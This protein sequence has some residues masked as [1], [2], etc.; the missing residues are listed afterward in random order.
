MAT[1][2]ANHLPLEKIPLVDLRLL[3]QTD[4]NSLSLHS[5]SSSSPDLFDDIIVPKIDR[6]NF[7]ESAGSRKQ[8]Y[9]R[10][11]LAPNN[12]ETSTPSIGRRR[13]CAA[14]APVQEHHHSSN[15]PNPNEDDSERKENK[16]IVSI[17]KD[18]FGKS[19][20]IV[21]IRHANA[22]PQLAVMRKRSR[23][24]KAVSATVAAPS[25]EGF[26]DEELLNFGANVVMEIVNRNGCVVDIAALGEVEDPF[27]SELRRRTEGLESEAELLGFMREL[28]GQWGSRRMKRK[29][30]DASDFGDTPYGQQFLS[31]K[32]VSS[33]LHSFFGPQ[34][35]TH[36]IFRQSDKD[37]LA[38][39][40]LQSTAGLKPK[41]EDT[42]DDV[43]YG[44]T[45]PTASISAEHEMQ[46]AVMGADNLADVEIRDL[47]ECSKCN[48]SFDEKDA[49]L[50]HLL[51]SCH[52]KNAKRSRLGTS[53]CDGVIIKDGKF[54]CQFCH[55]I[56]DERHRYNGHVGVHVR[57]YVRSLEASPGSVTAKMDDEPS[58]SEVHS[59]V[60]GASIDLDKSYILVTS[61]ATPNT[62]TNSG[63]PLDKLEVDSVLETY[64]AKSDHEV[65]VDFPYI[66]QGIGAF[67]AQTP[68][69]K[70]SHELNV[71]SPHSRP[72]IGGF[73]PEN[74]TKPNDGLSMD[75]SSNLAVG[76]VPGISIIKSSCE[77]NFISHNKQDTVADKSEEYS[78]SKSRDKCSEMIG[79]DVG[80]IDGASNSIDRELD[81]CW[82][83]TTA[84]NVD[85]SAFES[86]G[87][88][89]ILTNL[90]TEME[91]SGP[92]QET[93]SIS[94][95]N[96]LSGREEN[97]CVENIAN[98]VLPVSAK[99]SR[100]E[101]SE[102]RESKSC[103]Q[104]SQDA[105][106]KDVA[107]DTIEIT[108][109]E[110]SKVDKHC[111]DIEKNNGYEMTGYTTRK[112]DDCYNRV[113]TK[114]DASYEITGDKAGQT[115]EAF[116]TVD[117]EQDGHYEM[118]GNNMVKIDQACSSVDI[119]RN[120]NYG[121][122]LDK[123]RRF[124]EAAVNVDGEQDIGFEMTGDMVEKINEAHHNVDNEQDISY[125]MRNDSVK[126]I[127]KVPNNVNEGQGSGYEMTGGMVERID[128]S[129]ST[130]EGALNSCLDSAT[131]LFNNVGNSAFKTYDR[132]YFYTTP[133]GEIEKSSGAYNFLFGPSGN[134]QNIGTQAVGNGNYPVSVNEHEP[135]GGFGRFQ[136]GY[137]NNFRTETNETTHRASIHQ[138]P[139][140]DA[141]SLVPP[142]CNIPTLNLFS[143]KV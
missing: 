107:T 83:S 76:S 29:I 35:E 64:K 127:D 101:D 138:L 32:E 3:S 73:V 114:Q 121:M 143:E 27:G 50:E 43:C 61:A 70:A 11:R 69:E 39:Y 14:H 41:S 81:S 93:G 49:Y 91:K 90:S 16:Q 44:A 137:A 134:E 48:T 36:P 92:P 40:K 84:N 126:K 42:K 45:S 34:D 21:A 100:L 141:S 79:I 125:K 82:E 55:K 128:K 75:F 7:N 106:V 47:L 89:V 103:F 56:F 135:G 9:S 13:G 5:L 25:G 133:T 53:V 58:L 28:E 1:A 74:S 46:D 8:T 17:L 2:T 15:N 99:M 117:G 52:Q 124:G 63:S 112:I 139:A 108:D 12:T 54:E 57:S 113:N 30:V 96:L 95:P 10:L 23:K 136:A 38:A 59:R 120:S 116:D 71:G 31:C 98:E 24:R 105:S 129:Y 37:N 102:N 142:S 22:E 111:S 18:L 119:G 51:T 122:T 68:I 85:T 20:Q 110:I 80:K 4:L 118:V 87:Q 94:S 66:K 104:R 72:S 130:V 123:V 115:D 19:K 86:Y 26:Y 6:A 62:E 65:N 97:A 140:T 109:D 78:V 33:Y 131:A 132:N 77:P 88:K 67:V 60:S